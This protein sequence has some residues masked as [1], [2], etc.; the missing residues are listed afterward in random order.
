M[1]I[2]RYNDIQKTTGQEQASKL[3][4]LKIELI[5]SQVTANKTNA[6]TREIKRAIARILTNQ[7]QMQAKAPAVKAQPK[8]ISTSAK[9]GAEKK[10]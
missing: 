2:L 7:A 5:K 9:G 1:A 8:P 4:D 6:K 10:K 3:K